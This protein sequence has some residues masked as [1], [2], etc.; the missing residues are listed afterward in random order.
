MQK[1]NANKRKKFHFERADSVNYHTHW[2]FF[3]FFFHTIEYCCI[4]SAKFGRKMMYVNYLD[5]LAQYISLDQLIIP[6]QVI[7]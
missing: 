2:G 4:H 1:N 7:E 3:F 6:Q 5:E